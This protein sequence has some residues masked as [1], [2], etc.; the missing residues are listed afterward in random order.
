LGQILAGVHKR[1]Q[2][3]SLPWPKNLRILKTA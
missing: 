1:H 2:T 3:G